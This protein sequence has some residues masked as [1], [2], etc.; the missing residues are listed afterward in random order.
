MIGR[1]IAREE[2]AKILFAEV[3]GVVEYDVENDFH[4]AGVDLVD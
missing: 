3:A 4:I 1:P 2:F